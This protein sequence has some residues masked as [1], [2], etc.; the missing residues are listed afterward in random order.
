MPVRLAQKLGDTYKVFWEC[1][2]SL[3]EVIK[4]AWDYVGY[5]DNLDKLHEA[6]RE[7]MATPARGAI[8]SLVAWLENWPSLGPNSRS[9][10]T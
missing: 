3:L 9:L 4:D 10:W 5:V 8:R 7:T 6:L 1:E 2:S